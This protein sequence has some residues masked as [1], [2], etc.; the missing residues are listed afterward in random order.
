[1]RKII[2]V[3]SVVAVCL[4][5]SSC[6]ESNN[7]S[8]KNIYDTNNCEKSISEEQKQTDV[9]TEHNTTIEKNTRKVARES[10]YTSPNGG[11]QSQYKGS[12][13]QQEHLRMMDAMGW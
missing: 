8:S 12:L 7:K 6:L 9:R 1:M 2:K 10:G 5:L 11:R 3:L 4:S 13:E